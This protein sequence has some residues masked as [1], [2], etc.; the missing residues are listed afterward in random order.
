MAT[1]WPQYAPKHAQ[2]NMARQRTRFSLEIAMHKYDYNL[3]TDEPSS[4]RK[5]SRISGNGH[6]ALSINLLVERLVM[7]EGLRIIRFSGFR[8]DYY[9]IFE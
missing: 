3:N 9:S 1:Q 2:V 7:I 4:R 5:H 6:V 8:H